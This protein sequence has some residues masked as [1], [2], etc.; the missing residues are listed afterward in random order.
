MVRAY[1]ITESTESSKT[2][3]QCY[4]KIPQQRSIALYA[5]RVRRII[6]QAYG[7]MRALGKLHQTVHELG[8]PTVVLRAIVQ[9]DEQRRDMGKA[10]FHRLPPIDQPIYQTIAGHGWHVTAFRKSSSEAGWKMSTGVTLA[11][12]P[13]TS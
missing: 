1:W 12:S 4:S 5:A 8:T 7:E 10:L 9:N 3:F 6:R 11:A 2:P 13:T